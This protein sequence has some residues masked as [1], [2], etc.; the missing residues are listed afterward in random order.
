MTLITPWLIVWLT[1]STGS[2]GLLTALSP[3]HLRRGI[4]TDASALL[5]LLGAIAYL[6]TR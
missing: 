6:L 2:L 5:A 1:A 3:P 4:L